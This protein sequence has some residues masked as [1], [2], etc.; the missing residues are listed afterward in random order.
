MGKDAFL[1]NSD[2]QKATIVIPVFNEEENISAVI[3]ELA[4]LNDCG[5]DYEVLFVDDGSSDGTLNKI[6]D[7]SVTKK[8]IR[9][10]SFSRNFGHQN[11]I[12]AGL[13]W[14]SGD[15][16]ITMDGDLQHP[17]DLVPDMLE[18][19]RAGYDVVFTTRRDVEDISR[20][21]RKTAS[22][23][24]SL[25]NKLSD[26][27]LKHGSADFRLMD[28]K[29]VDA[30]KKFNESTIFYRGLVAWLGFKQYEIAYTPSPRHKGKSKYSLKKMLSLAINGITAFSV[31]P[32]RAAAIAGFVIALSSFSYV[33]Y[34]LCIKLFTTK[35][36]SGWLSIM[37][38][39]YLLGGIQLIFLGLC[40]EY[41]GK[42][43]MEVKRRPNY[44]ITEMS[45][46]EES[47]Q[48]P[49]KD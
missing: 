2:S 22:W 46:P 26:I 3:D 21:K 33:L 37:A 29:V 38:G 1:G 47:K 36:V 6:K 15:V 35:A 24:Y 31:F 27:E 16:V 40:G 10:I 39:V 20:L 30:L 23:Y 9:F 25:L 45:L 7:A 44:L 4:I 11:A 19:W 34:A 5:I 48:S 28:R 8:N 12:R 17:V 13:E 41:I 14:S 43:F 32:L 18:K 49:E 42:T